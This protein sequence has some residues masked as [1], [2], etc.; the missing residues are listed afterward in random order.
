MAEREFG[1]YS[2]WAKTNN[3]LLVVTWDEDSFRADNRIPT[4]F[5]GA[6]LQ[7][8]QIDTTYTLHNLLRTIDDMYDLPHSGAAAKVNPIYGA[9]VGEQPL[10]TIT[11]V[12]RSGVDG[13]TGTQDTEL[14]QFEP[15]SSLGSET[16]ITVDGDNLNLAGNQPSQGLIRFDQ[17][18]GIVPNRFHQTPPSTL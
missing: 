2:Q 5:A 18:V 14:R 3:S 8:G 6:N 11:R 17:I 16:K 10:P 1:A 15:A 9:F 4:I 13:Y 12:F 7:P